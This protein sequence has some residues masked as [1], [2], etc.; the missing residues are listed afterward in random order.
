MLRTN[1]SAQTAQPQV[2]RARADDGQLL[3]LAQGQKCLVAGDEPVRASGQGSTDNGGVAQVREG[4]RTRL[5]ISSSVRMPARSAHGT[6]AWR[7]SHKA[8]T[9]TVRTLG[10]AS[11]CRIEIIAEPY[12]QDGHGIYLLSPQVYVLQRIP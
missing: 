6:K 9:A 11:E 8:I 2:G 10:Q 7:A 5:K 1:R 12:G 4:F 3:D